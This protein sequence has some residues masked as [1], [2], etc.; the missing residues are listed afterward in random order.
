M[1]VLVFDEVENKIIMF[2][3]NNRPDEKGHF[4][5]KFGGS[6]RTLDS[7]VVAYACTIEDENDFIEMMDV[8]G[9]KTVG[10]GTLLIFRQENEDMME[11]DVPHSCS[12]PIYENMIREDIYEPSQLHETEFGKPSVMPDTGLVGGVIANNDYAES[13]QLPVTKE[14]DVSIVGSQTLE[15]QFLEASRV[16][17]TYGGETLETQ[18]LEASRVPDTYGVSL[19][20]SSLTLGNF[21]SLIQQ[22]VNWRN[23]DV[24]RSRSNWEGTNWDELMESSSWHE[25]IGLLAGDDDPSD[26]ESSDDELNDSDEPIDESGGVDCESV[27]IDVVGETSVRPETEGIYGGSLDISGVAKTV[28]VQS[29]CIGTNESELLN[30]KATTFNVEKLPRTLKLIIPDIPTDRVIVTGLGSKRAPLE[31]H[32]DSEGEGHVSMDVADKD[33]V[34]DSDCMLEDDGIVYGDEFSGSDSPVC[35]I[36]CFRMAGVVY[37]VESCC[38]A[39]EVNGVDGVSAAGVENSGGHAE[40]IQGSFGQSYQLLNNYSKELRKVDRFNFIELQRVGNTDCFKCYFWSYGITVRSF[41]HTCRPHIEIDGTHLRG[42]SRGCLI[43]A[44][45]VDGDNHVF[46]VSFGLVSGEDNENYDWF[47]RCLGDQVVW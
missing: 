5:C 3:G 8:H 47:L 28:L 19:G 46:P 31:L 27:K 10:E 11:E 15:T 29:S 25:D 26:Y 44:I 2:I 42:R 18:F 4:I 38:H 34:M 35:V 45:V 30:V 32:N 39:E 36:A 23:T 14:V 1:E 22:V 17:D 40:K 16:P 6:V 24:G 43:S 41:R 33:D 7:G 37:G 13:F 12:S 21:T 20:E 9:R